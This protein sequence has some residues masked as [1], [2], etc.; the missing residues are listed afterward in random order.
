MDPKIA[1]TKTNAKGK[2]KDISSS[3][4]IQTPFPL[5]YRRC[6]KEFEKKHKDRL[7]VKQYVW[8]ATE[9][10]KL[11]LLEVV[12]FVSHQ[13][14]DYFFQLSQDYNED[15]IRVFYSGLYD[16]DGSY[17]KFTIGN[18]VYEFTDDLWK[19]LFGIT[20]IDPDV[21]DESDSLV[22]D[23][24]AHIYYRGN[25]IVNKMLRDLRPE[26]RFKP[27]TTYKL[28]MVPRILWWLVSHV[29]YPRNGGFSRIDSSKVHLI[30]IF[31]NKVKINWP[32]YIV[33]R[34]QQRYFF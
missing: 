29:L 16:K 18:V 2:G 6:I 3:K 1:K 8:K 26:G 4:V 23:V 21:G 7:V 12:N 14:I 13:K 5:V 9:V 20:I 34:M 31:L 24:H 11:A 28:N 27:L 33:S 15:L 19:S 25:T 22:P 30:Y 17:F 32:H 10:A